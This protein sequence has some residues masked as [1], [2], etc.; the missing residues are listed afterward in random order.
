MANTRVSEAAETNVGEIKH[1]NRFAFGENWAS[2]LR[3]LDSDRIELAMQALREMFG[4]EDLVGRRFLDV[5]SGSGLSSLA[6]RRLGAQVV[7]FDYDPQSVACTQELRRRYFPQDEDMWK[8]FEG[9]ALDQAWL[10]GLGKFDAVYSWGVLHHTGSMWRAMVNVAAAVAPGGQ[11]FLALYNDQ[12]KM[13]RIY[14]HL[15]RFYC[16][17]P[18]VM[19]KVIVLAYFLALWGPR[20]AK[21]SLALQPLRRWKAY[22][23][24]R[25]MSAWHD[26]VDWV[27]GFPFEVCS[28]E[29]V[30]AWAR[31]GG[32]DFDCMNRIGGGAGCNQFVFT[33]TGRMPR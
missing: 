10:S 28:Q 12:G 19:R 2:F 5:G 9:S 33:L 27:G 11:L 15:K 13:S 18:Y 32:F 7:S 17:S 8:V 25:G 14:W 3:V 1:G 29:Q 4:V 26:I 22:N 31:I 30:L 20:I 6:A 24:L 23:H 21:D 16:R